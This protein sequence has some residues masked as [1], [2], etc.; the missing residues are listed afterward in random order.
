MS[1][2]NWLKLAPP[3][4]EMRASATGTV[5]TR[6][7]KTEYL[8][9]KTFM[10][11]KRF[12]ELIVLQHINSLDM[13]RTWYSALGTAPI[14]RPRSLRITPPHMRCWTWLEK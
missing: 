7:G 6:V 3:E 10:P 12:E 9:L 14:L 11:R 8:V 5:N 1:A 4:A 2:R 13:G